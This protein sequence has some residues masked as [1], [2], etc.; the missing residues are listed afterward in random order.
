[1]KEFTMDGFVTKG[2]EVRGTNSGRMVTKFSL[3]SPTY[4][5]E[6][7]SNTPQ[8]FDCE[9]WWNGQ[10]DYKARNIVEGALLLIRGQLAQ[11]TWQDRNT[12]QNRSK[13]TL[14]VREIGV[15]RSAQP[16]AQPAPQQAPQMATT[17]PQQ[18]VQPAAAAPQQAVAAPP[19]AA[20][21]QMAM[22]QPAPQQAP[23]VVDASIYDVD[24]PF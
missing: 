18:A 5:R 8:F 2:V 20:P 13:V 1:M 11:D 16:K 9:Y 15:I 19:M 22:Q 12:G 6:T 17:A 3:N 23:Q 21:Q 7:N 24:I 4:N 10:S 14:K